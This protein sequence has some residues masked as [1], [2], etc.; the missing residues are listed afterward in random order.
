MVN[1]DRLIRARGDV[2]KILSFPATGKVEWSDPGELGKFEVLQGISFK[3]FD[4][5]NAE[6]GLDFVECE[7]DRCQFRG[8]RTNGRLWG[9]GNRWKSCSFEQCDFQAMGA[10]VNSFF[11]CRF[12]TFS[13]QN[14][15][16]HQTFFESCAFAHTTIEGLK[17]LLVSNRNI[18]N[19]DFNKTPGQI[20]FRNCHFRSSLFRQCYFEGVV[21]D[22]CTFTSVDA[23][24]CSFEGISSDVKWWGEQKTDPF[25]VFLGKALELVKNKC[26]QKSAA[27]R[28]FESYVIDYGCGRTN[29]RDFSAC[30]YSNRVPYD[31]T[32]LVMDELL[33]LVDKF[34]F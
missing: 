25:T 26:G 23:H 11:D 13:I 10:P 15:R 29:S 16:P 34:P 19:F 9:R 5:A 2:R 18:K 24:A 22:R 14:F 8:I 20:V 7:F 21:F 4:I 3:E 6:V 17:A 12:E 28:E 33:H 31:E 30:L 27:Y 1:V 32:E